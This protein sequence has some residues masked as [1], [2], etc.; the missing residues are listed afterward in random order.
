MRRWLLAVSGLLLVTTSVASAQ[1]NQPPVADAGVDQDVPEWTVVTLSG[2]GSYDPEDGGIRQYAWAQLSG[3]PVE[4]IPTFTRPNPQFTAP[5]VSQDTVLTFQLTVYD[6]AFLSSTDTVKITVHNTNTPPVANAG[7]DVVQDE[8]SI[9]TL[10]GSASMDPDGEPLTYMWTQTAGPAVLLNVPTIAKPTFDAPRLTS[11]TVLTFQLT[12]SDASLSSSD[13]VN[14]TLR[15]V[16]AP[17]IAHAGVNWSGVRNTV[18]RLD[19]TGSWDPDPDAVLSFSWAQVFGPPVTLVNADTARPSF[20]VPDAPTGTEVRFELTVSDGSL[21]STADVRIGIIDSTQPPVANAGW[22]Q[23]ISPGQMVVLDGSESS[24]P[25]HTVLAY[26]WEQLSG[27][28]VTIRGSA[29]YPNAYFDAPYDA[30]DGTVLTFQLTVNDGYA[31]STDTVDIVVRTVLPPP[32]PNAGPDQ[33][34]D[35]RAVVTLDGSGSYDPDGEHLLYGWQQLS[36]PPVQLNGNYD[37]PM[38]TFTAPDVTADTVLTFQILV[39]DGSPY[40]TDTVDITV[41]SVNRAP[42][43][44]AGSPQ[45]VNEHGLVTLDG[46]G[47]GDPDQDPL[48]YA[49]EQTS[50]PPMVLAG[51]NTAQPTFTP[52]VA[53]DSVLTFRLTV[54]DGV[55]SSTDTVSV[56]VRDV[57]R[58]PVARAGP[59]RWMDERTS[60]VLD[61]RESM[62]PDA[63]T[64]LT[65]AWV[66]TAGPSVQLTGA[67]TAQATFIAPEVSTS[68]QLVFQLTVS[69]GVL[70]QTD[71]VEIW[72]AQVNRPPVANAGQGIAV[73]GGARVTLDGRGSADPDA[74]ST[75]TYLWE[76][77]EGPEAVLSGAYI[78]QPTVVVPAV[79]A[80]AVLTF[81]LTVSDGSLAS[82]DTVRITVHRLNRA[83]VAHAGTRREVDER[84]QVTLDGRGSSDPDQDSLS[85][86]WTQKEGPA[87]TLTGATSAQPVFTA[88]EVTAT[89]VLTFQLVVSDGGA[90]SEPKTVSLT[91]RNV[92]R[93]PVAHAGEDQ[94]VKGGARVTLGGS[95]EDPDSDGMSYRWVQTAGPTMTL[96]DDTDVAPTFTAPGLSWDEVLTFTLKVTDAQGASAEDSV[97]ITVKALPD[98]P[99]DGDGEGSG[100]GCSSDSSAA[101]ALLPLVLLGLLLRSRRRWPVH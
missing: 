31:S 70:S 68:T 73:E 98:L 8:Y 88:P 18:L 59:D 77:T 19:G 13:T 71:L 42:V 84:T 79:T 22:N 50:G 47:S 62:D 61:G 95:G 28:P 15:N 41:R 87:V 24:D 49:W 72:V 65:Y 58:R 96:S 46:R 25:E 26:T 82:T 34:V 12:V 57:N 64:V 85:Y 1:S 20:V 36:G 10:D 83:P 52:E 2:L 40:R 63:D 60:G 16:N 45:T 27:P 7:V 91:V 30:A 55:V 53:V 56:T 37:T 39:S 92:N 99:S 44:R 86:V 94:S 4:L 81:K 21:F 29:Q 80:D 97:S 9:V 5:R 54:S 101:G 93:M 66:Q 35:E 14:V 69:D 32:V 23:S 48:T 74:D 43:A 3:P 75:L 78:A 33:T 89:T 90:S 11:D 67:D 6:N 76:Q 38:A 17:P 100:C 51:A